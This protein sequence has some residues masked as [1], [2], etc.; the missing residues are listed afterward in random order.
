VTVREDVAT[1]VAHTTPLPPEAASPLA[2]F[3]RKANDARN[4]LDY[5]IRNVGRVR[6]CRMALLEVVEAFERFLKET[7][8]RCIDEVAPNI[9]DDRFADLKVPG[10][11]LAL[12]FAE[13]SIGKALSESD[14]WLDC[15]SINRRFQR[16]LA[17]PFR[18]DTKFFALPSEQQDRLEGWRQTTL[19]VVFQMRHTIVHNAGVLTRSD[20]AKLRL[21]LRRHVDAPAV[22]WPER[23]DVIAVKEFLNDLATWMTGRVAQR[24]GALLSEF[25][26]SDPTLFDAAEKAQQLADGLQAP[27][28]VSGARAVPRT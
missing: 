2:H 6:T 22:L 24:L 14:T 7:A 16:V 18:R 10:D 5:V 1:I 28:E 4:L 9:A 12:H 23:G 25:H 15:E 17:D 21:L 26:T 13:G 20:A 27:V 3:E 19:E 8:A 11:R